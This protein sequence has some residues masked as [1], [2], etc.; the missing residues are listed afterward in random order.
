MSA[1]VAARRAGSMPTARSIA[2]RASAAVESGARGG[3]A[4]EGG[5]VS[6]EGSRGTSCGSRLEEM[7]NSAS[8]QEEIGERWRRVGLQAKGGSKL[9][10]APR[11]CWIRDE[12]QQNW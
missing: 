11:G 1:A 2:G 10:G 9:E 8:R 6:E 12:G 7:G 3:V 5:D 4:E